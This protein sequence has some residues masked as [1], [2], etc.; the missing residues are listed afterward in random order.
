MVFFVDA[1]SS[2]ESYEKYAVNEKKKGHRQHKV[3][4]ELHLKVQCVELSDI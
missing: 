4:L 3:T 2:K 1:A